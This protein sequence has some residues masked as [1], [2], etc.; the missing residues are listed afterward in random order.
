MS[1]AADRLDDRGVAPHDSVATTRWIASLV[2][3]LA[4]HVGLLL[5]LIARPIMTEA[6]GEPPAA[7]LIQL[8]PAPEPPALIAAPPAP[9]P[10]PPQAVAPEP[11][12]PP[13]PVPAEIPEPPPPPKAVALPKPPPPPRP[14]KP[15]SVTPPR[16]QPA[17]PAAE[18]RPVQPRPLEPRPAAPPSAAPQ[19]PAPP[20][21]SPGAIAGAR[22][23]WQ[24]QLVG[25]LARYKR[26]PRVA[27]EQRQEGI[28]A[29]VF[30]M[31]RGGRVLAAH[32][33]RSSGFSL[34]D[35]EA[36]ALIQRAQPL[37]ALPADVPGS[38]VQLVVPIAFKI[39]P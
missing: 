3:V 14:A 6:P 2:A 26:Y 37:P 32:I 4:I 38:V 25:W 19:P 33:E 28:V 21:P 10:Q 12:S 9:V 20:Q 34:L 31:D 16:P 18:P 30:T 35:D 13:P 1:I 5:F 27:Q 17:V 23:N 11:Q 36:M 8:A 24:A 15:R 7:V 29:L 39:H 22:A